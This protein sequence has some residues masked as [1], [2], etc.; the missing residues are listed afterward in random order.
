M[1]L[2]KGTIATIIIFLIALVLGLP[3]SDGRSAYAYWELVRDLNATQSLHLGKIIFLGPISSL[4]GFH[5]PPAYYYV[6]YPFAR[7][8]NF[9]PY[10]LAVASLFFSLATMALVFFVVK[11]WWNN[12]FLAFTTISLMAVSILN[13]QLNK[14]GSNPNFIP[15]FSLLFFYSLQQLIERPSDLK[16]TALLA[17]AFSIVTQLHAVPMVAMPIILSALIIRKKLK[18]NLLSTLVFIFISSIAYSPYLF[19]EFTHN[20]ENFRSLLVITGGHGDFSILMFHYVQYVGFW[21]S[22]WVSLHTFFDVSSLLGFKFYLLI[23]FTLFLVP[24]VLHY[25]LKN[26]RYYFARLHLNVP[27]SVKTVVSYWLLVPTVILFLPIGATNNYQIYYFLIFSPLIFILMAL[28]LGYIFKQGLH[29]LAG[30]LILIFVVLQIIQIYL[31]D[32]FVSG[33][34]LNF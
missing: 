9:A 22:P 34:K 4:G 14:Y 32:V 11:K 1:S 20:F 12:N 18:L 26:R 25:N 5:F 29:L 24:L 21:L 6:V 27:P 8:F 19:Y 23:A 28:G 30:L 10:S 2:K 7:V 13:V 31:Y 3:Y 16:Y 33:I 17:T 15:F